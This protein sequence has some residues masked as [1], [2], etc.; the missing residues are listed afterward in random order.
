MKNPWQTYEERHTWTKELP[1]QEGAYWW[2]AKK[3]A[4]KRIVFISMN[5]REMHALGHGALDD[6]LC[7]CEGKG[8]WAGPI[9]EPKE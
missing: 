9:E 2:R 6:R 4:I 5:G 8:E 7:K 1:T 3:D